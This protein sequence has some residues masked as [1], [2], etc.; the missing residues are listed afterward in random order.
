VRWT[1]ALL[2]SFAG[3]GVVAA[4]PAPPVT[5]PDAAPAGAPATPSAVSSAVANAPV[6][7]PTVPAV[8]PAAADARSDTAW[9]LY[10]DAFSALMHDEPSRARS[11]ASALLRRHPDHPASQLV[12]GAHLSLGPGAVD[13]P[14]ATGE[15]REIRET[16]SRGARAEL[17]LFQSVNGVAIGV[18]ICL[19]LECDSPE[20]ALALALA[21]GVA[22]AAISLGVDNLTSG[23]RALLNSGTFW[24]AVNAS[25]LAATIDDPSPELV[26][27]LLL[28]GQGGGLV[29]GASMFGTHATAGQVALANSGGQWAAVLTTLLI[30]ASG[31]EMTLDEQAITTLVTID[32]GLGVGAYLAGLSP[33]V[34]RAQTLVIDAG[35]IAGV[36]GGG[37][38]GVVLAGSIDDRT[39]PALAAVGAAIGLGTAAY[40]TR[41][42]N[43][44]D[45]SS[46]HTFV[47]P[48]AQGTGGVAGVSF[49][50]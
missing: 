36:V 21:G 42:W 47:A 38:L 28:A 32:L 24:G 31:A 34:S 18:E 10:H 7:A 22:G 44:G 27:G 8:L 14:R 25:L 46:L 19:A 15:A 16:A 9:Q 35:G 33:Q 48:P 17:A 43:R 49:T 23:Q 13:D 3:L 11:L 6:A 50:W 41:D 40:F 20:A 30:G 29:L 37:G 2:C 39:T 1:A 12:R 26:G 45:E 5:A 4:Q